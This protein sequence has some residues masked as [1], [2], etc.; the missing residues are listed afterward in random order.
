MK[1]FL[2]SHNRGK[3]HEIQALLADSHLE[4]DFAF[5]IWVFL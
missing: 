2:A 5:S 4:L 1:I 3:L